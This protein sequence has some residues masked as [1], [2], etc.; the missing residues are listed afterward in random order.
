M[1]GI[2]TWSYAPYKP[3]LSDV[4]D[5]Y[6]CRVA[7]N[8]NSIHLEWLGTSDEYKIYYRKRNGD[9]FISAGKTETSEFDI[10]DLENETEYEF[11]VSSGN[12]KSR[13]RFARTCEAIG[14]VV[15]YLHPDDDAYAFSGKYLA[16]PSL[17]KHPDGYLLAS[18]DI[19]GP[20]TPQNLTLIYR[21][22][23]NGQSW[24]YLSELMPCFW[25][26][27]FV[28]N[29]EIYMMSVS[30][31]YGDLLIGKS[32][33]GG[34]TF[35]APVCL[36]RGSNGKNGFPGFHKAPQNFICRNGR[37]YFTVEWGS[38]GNKAGYKHA[39]LML[40]ID[41]NDDLLVPENWT[42][43]N[44]IKFEV[45]ASEL[46]GL[47]SNAMT[48]EGTPV[49]TPD[50]RIM[51]VM[52]FQ[53]YGYA[54]AYELDNEES[55][56]Y[57][58]IFEF[59]TNDSKFTIKHDVISGNYYSII[60]EKCDDSKRDDR[61]ILS[62]AVSGDLKT[63]QIAARLIDNSHIDPKMVGFQYVDFDFDGDDIIF[64]CRTAW[65]NAHDYHDSNYITFHRIK[66]FRKISQRN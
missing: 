38:W 13:V 47:T 36:M 31:E 39:A 50:G 63:W 64:L 24:H 22:D 5:I 41:A 14:A 25:G 1:R 59:P 51:N 43:T 62:L 53:K 34:K 52:R 26:K 17:L 32:T 46:E 66:D 30:T 61:N 55:L 28:H 40:S 4:E 11:Y 56:S 2:N 16:S 44:P 45:F 60:N 6:I 7:P 37:L 27:L 12:K 29:G 49:V 15:N 8:E 18:T 20:L 9:I 33:D 19:F 3:L 57:S 42:F 54:L 58:H 10:T 65:N 23:D 21:S 35:S 48:I